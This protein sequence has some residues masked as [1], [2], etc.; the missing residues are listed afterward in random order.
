MNMHLVVVRPFGRFSR[1]Q[2]ILDQAQIAS[3]LANEHARFVV[4]VSARMPGGA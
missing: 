1:G 3:I 4:Q 2:I